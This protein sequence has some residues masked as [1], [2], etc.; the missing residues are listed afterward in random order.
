[1]KKAGGEEVCYQAGSRFGRVLSAV[2]VI[3]RVIPWGN[4]SGCSG[5][6][7]EGSLFYAVSLSLLFP[8]F[9]LIP[10]K[11]LVMLGAGKKREVSGVG[12]GV[13]A[14]N[15]FTPLGGKGG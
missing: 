15:G 4:C 10:K 7:R 9:N 12:I 14:G 8:S 6:K 2:D 3:R 13:S 1:M 5:L 11:D